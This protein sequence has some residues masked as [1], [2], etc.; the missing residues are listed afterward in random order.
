MAK[1]KAK[2]KKKATQRIEKIVKYAKELTKDN[3]S[4]QEAIKRAGKRVK[5]EKGRD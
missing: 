2:S 3:V 4:W 5:M 1:D